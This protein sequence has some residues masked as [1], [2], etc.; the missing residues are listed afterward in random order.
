MT[1]TI[2]D[3]K[4]IVTGGNTGIGKATAEEF[5]R[6]GARVLISARDA[7]KGEA[8]VASI[9]ERVPGAEVSWGFLDL[10]RRD[11]VREFAAEVLASGDPLDVLIHN[12]GLVLTERREL[13]GGIEATFGINHLG[14]FFLNQLLEPRLRESAPSRVV[15][16]ASRAHVRKLGGL[17]FDDLQARRA[18]S[19]GVVYGASKLANILFTRELARRLEGSG[20]TA[21]CLH[22]GVVATDF[23][24]DG[25]TK[26]LWRI[27]FRYFRF[28]MLSPEQ[29]ARTSVHLACDPGLAQRSG[30]YYAACKEQR[31]SA[32]ARDDQAARRLWEVSEEL[33]SG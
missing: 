32:A 6:R 22:P 23:A 17:D 30:G 3:K 18:Y 28:L 26:G 10:G 20:V 24:G 33:V 27:V 1:W 11:S 9:R 25:D 19:A 2:R 7:A 16:V 13:A 31:P 14:P 12:A 15:V 21:N 29:G 5:C 4:V 8:A